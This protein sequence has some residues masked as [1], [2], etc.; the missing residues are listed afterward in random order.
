VSVAVSSRGG[1]FVGTKSFTGNPYDGH[2][3]ASQMKQVESLIANQVSEAYVDM[4]YRGHDYDGAVTCMSTRDEEDV[5]LKHD[6]D[7]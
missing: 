5:H 4:G 1:W 7:G 6:G 3:L 2:T